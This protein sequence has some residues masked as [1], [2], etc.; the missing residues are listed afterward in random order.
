MATK[1]LFNRGN[2]LIDRPVGNSGGVF[3]VF[4]RTMEIANRIGI[5]V[6]S[7]ELNSEF[8]ERTVKVDFYL[9]LHIERP[10]E[11]S[12]LLINDGQDLVT[13]GFEKL[14]EDFHQQGL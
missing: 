10:E 8:L 4:S 2:L 6:E 13:M 9:P 12:L 1:R 5:I 3:F 14:L 7:A 11:L